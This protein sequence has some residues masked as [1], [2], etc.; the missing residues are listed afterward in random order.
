[1]HAAVY[2][3]ALHI[4]EKKF[5]GKRLDKMLQKYSRAMTNFWPY[6]R[7]RMREVDERKRIYSASFLRNLHVDGKV[8]DIHPQVWASPDDERQASIAVR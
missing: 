7:L 5:G 8:L 4:L 1:M 2:L 3:S 6:L